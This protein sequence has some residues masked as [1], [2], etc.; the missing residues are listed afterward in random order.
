MEITSVAFYVF[1]G[2]SLLIYWKLPHKYQW[3]LL[4]VDSLLFYFANSTYYT[5]IYIII[6]VISVYYVTNYFRKEEKASNKK[7]LL[8]LTII[9]NIGILVVLKYTNLFINT[10][11]FLG[12][13]VLN[14]EGISNVKWL[15]PLAISYY[16]LQMVS[17]LLDCYWEMAEPFSNPL[18]LLLYCIYF[19]LMV[20]G[21][22]CRYSEIGEELFNYHAFSYD[23]TK[24][25]LY[26]IAWGLMKKLTISNRL[27]I[28]VN[29]MWNNPI[30]S[31]GINV[32][33]SMA[34][35][36]FQLYTDFSGCMDIV[37]GVSNCF[38]INPPENFNAP[39]L[40][41]ST[42]EF[43]QR[44]HITLGSWFRDYVMS[45]LLKSKKFNSF[46]R[47]C[48]AKFG[49]TGKKIPAYIASLV[50][51]IGIG[52]WH[53][54]S[55]KYVLMGFW[56]WFIIT[57]SQ[58]LNPTYKTIINKLKINVDSILWKIFQVIRT[59]VTYMFGAILFRADSI[60][61]AFI[62]IKNSFNVNFSLQFL[63]DIRLAV[64]FDDVSSYYGLVAIAVGL[65]LV[66]IID[67]LKYKEE[68]YIKKLV[69]SKWY[70]RWTIYY[71]IAILL[72][73]S[74][75]I[76]NQEILYAQF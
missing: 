52:I 3:L 18:K 44:W 1:V 9:L 76:T 4:L 61:D 70:V 10:F 67:Y 15:A 8:V 19:P 43:W 16:T 22:I 41:K 71:L 72:I 56:F 37:I 62:R 35:F 73:T 33:I 45:P 59:F 26:R 58:I 29:Q 11:N 23:R 54:N 5:F 68:D 30:T 20:S 27:A 42:Q 17:Y 66:F 2:I 28:I 75:D 14:V 49:K 38:G 55:W 13:K 6:S 40:S 39:L 57:I 46:S 60:S 25:G 21:P 50:V 7:K 53:G 64:R 51:W 31:T 65:I 32:W 74:L 24:R 48:K 63:K 69:N 36:V 34:L 47:W 12:S